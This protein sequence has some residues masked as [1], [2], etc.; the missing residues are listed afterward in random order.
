MRQE[1]L[2]Q[3]TEPVHRTTYWITCDHRC[4]H[5]KILHFQRSRE[6]V[7]GWH[8]HRAIDRSVA[9]RRFS[10]MI[11]IP[12][13]G[14][15]VLVNVATKGTLYTVKIE[16][17]YGQTGLVMMSS[18]AVETFCPEKGKIWRIRAEANQM[19]NTSLN[20]VGSHSPNEN[21]MLIILPNEPKQG[22]RVHA[23]RS[24]N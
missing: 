16:I 5:P 20:F 24:G 10:Q 21:G 14:S 1:F 19:A 2:P 3:E 12:L 22:D 7:Q 17:S 9:C 4:I 15:R 13:L 11:Y 6:G 23:M 18:S 8:V